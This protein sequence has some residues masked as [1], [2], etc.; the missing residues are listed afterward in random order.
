[1]CISCHFAHG[2]DSGFMS[3]AD[4]T[5]VDDPTLHLGGTNDFVGTNDLNP[6]SALKRYVNMAVCWQCHA[7]S[8]AQLIKNATWY[9]EDYADGR[10]DW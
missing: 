6:S 9:W 3:L 7:N 8:S 4:G 10:G 5:L 2:A 1:M